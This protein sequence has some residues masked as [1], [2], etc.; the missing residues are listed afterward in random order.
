MPK[1][2]HLHWVI[3]EVPELR[4]I[5]QPLWDEA[6]ARQG[7][8]KTKG[9][10]DNIWDRRRPRTLFSGLLKCG[11]CGGGF[12]K[13]SQTQFGCST[14]RNKGKS[15][16]T[17]R[18]TISKT[19]LE[20]R[21]LG[22]LQ[23]NLMDQDLLEVFC[24]EYAKERNRL[25][26]EAEHGRGALEKELATVN[27]DHAKLVDAIIAGIPADQVKDKMQALT[28]RRK[29]LEAQL[30]HTAPSDPIRIHPNMAATYQTRVRSLI[31]GLSKTGEMQEAQEA[32][33]S[34]VDKIVLQPSPE[35]AKLDIV[36]EGALSGLLTLALGVKRRKGLSLKNQAFDN[37]GELV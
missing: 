15:L 32:L 36:L 2:H 6:K 11:F 10:I 21:V 13:V 34:L 5:E 14:A 31:S 20:E 17:N 26:A 33:R 23:D 7:A 12:S 9:T 3:T 22:A 35:R 28:E 37:V 4:I 16:C 29:A 8:L 24:K 27:R 30:S 19:D 18:L 25:N 1:L